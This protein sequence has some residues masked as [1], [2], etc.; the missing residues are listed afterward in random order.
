MVAYDEAT[1]AIIKT[2]GLLGYSSPSLTL[3]ITMRQAIVQ[4]IIK[5]Y[6]VL[7]DDLPLD[8]EGQLF[9]EKRRSQYWL[10]DICYDAE[11]MATDSGAMNYGVAIYQNFVIKVV[12]KNDGAYDLLRRIH[13]KELRSRHF[14]KV[15]TFITLHNVAFVV[16]ERLQPCKEAHTLSRELRSM[17]FRNVDETLRQ[18]FKGIRKFH[19]RDDCHSGNIMIRGNGVVV[20]VDPLA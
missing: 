11:R 13:A 16:M 6:K 4:R 19:G 1:L 2:Q 14:P 8:Y 17:R 5:E 12:G 7:V 20:L 10:R 18:T 15:Y 3:E 9:I